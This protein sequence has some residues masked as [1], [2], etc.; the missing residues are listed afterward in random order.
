MCG[1]GY[2]PDL[3]V[4]WPGAEISLMSPEGAVNI[5]SA[6][7][8][9]HSALVEQYRSRIGAEISAREGLID[10]VIDPRETARVVVSQLKLLVPKHDNE[11]FQLQRKKHGV[12]PV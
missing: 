6:P 11:R 9:N 12:S 3:I 5:I 7:G 10:D 1:K 8:G 2:D 4:A